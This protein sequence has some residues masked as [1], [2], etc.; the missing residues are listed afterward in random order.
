MVQAL[1]SGTIAATLDDLNAK[2]AKLLATRKLPI[3]GVSEFP[4]PGEAP[5]AGRTARRGAGLRR[6]GLA[7]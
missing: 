4:N 5:V 6:P 2:R 3:T 1:A 7:A